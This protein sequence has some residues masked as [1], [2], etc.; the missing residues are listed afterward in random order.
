M[1]N[2]RFL[3]RRLIEGGTYSKSKIFD[4]KID[5]K[6]RL[7]NTRY[8]EFIKKKEKYSDYFELNIIVNFI[9]LL[10]LASNNRPI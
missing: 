10:L 5:E 6:K 4:S 7:S 2:S 8:K 3:V 9:V 1:Q